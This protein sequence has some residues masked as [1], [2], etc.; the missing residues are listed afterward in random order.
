MA[1][2][3]INKNQAELGIKTYDYNVPTNHISRFVVEFIEEVYPILGIK[4][5]KKKRG[6]P[7]YPPCSML[8]LLVYAKIDHIGSARVI[9]EMAK[10][11]DIYKF[12]CDR[13]TPDERSIQRYRNDL[14]PYYEVLLQSTLKMAE[15]KDSR[16]LITLQSMEPS[17]K[18][19][20]PTKI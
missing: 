11:H 1:M 13:I 14:G 16:N 4:E 7:S 17:R 12:V 20:I 10:Y 6:R 19:I 2:K 3:K 5:N 9:E 15:K 18:H 8:K